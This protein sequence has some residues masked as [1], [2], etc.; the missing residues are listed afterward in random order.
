MRR[1]PRFMKRSPRQ[2]HRLVDPPPP[3]LPTAT[4]TTTTNRR[5]RPARPTPLIQ[6][7]GI[8]PPIRRPNNMPLITA[9]PPIIIT[10]TRPPPRRRNRHIQLM[11]QRGPPKPRVRPVAS[12]DT[13][14]VPPAAPPSPRL[15]DTTPITTA[16][17]NPIINVSG[18]APAPVAGGRLVRGRALGAAL[19]GAEEAREEHAE[20][21]FQ[22]GQAGA[23][24]AEVGFDEGPDAALDEVVGLVG[25][26]VERV[27]DR[28]DAEDGGDC[29]A[30]EKGWWLVWE[31]WAE[32]WVG[33]E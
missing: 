7:N 29:D 9:P 17:G 6:L 15:G 4:A 19:D 24:D 28:G 22:H 27:L 30:G 1:P 10:L 12:R 16:L 21:L 32:G 3:F 2:L 23:D 31:G 18:A 13:R 5:T 25:A 26:V 20:R 14:P 33:E 8:T 11:L